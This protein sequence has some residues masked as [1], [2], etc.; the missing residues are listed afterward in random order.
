M[1]TV[2]IA[3]GPVTAWFG[4][5]VPQAVAPLTFERVAG[6]HSCLTFIVTDA[7]GERFVLRRRR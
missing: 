3:E 2:G 7:A 1:T 5:H 6:G 4:V